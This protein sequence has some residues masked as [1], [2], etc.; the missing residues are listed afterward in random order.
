[1]S[2]EPSANGDNG[3]PDRGKNGRFI[4]GN[5]GGPGNPSAARVGRLR[6][7]ML[8]A[9]TTADM[10]SIVKALVSKAKAGDVLA[11]RLLFDRLLGPAVAIDFEGRLAELESL[12]EGNGAHHEPGNEAATARAGG[13]GR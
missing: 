13:S 6:S 10:A 1:M 3:K 9:V 4:R 11:A 12:L 7:A 2:K 5:P 8:G